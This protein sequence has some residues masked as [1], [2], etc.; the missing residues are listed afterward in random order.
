MKALPIPLPKKRWL[1]SSAWELLIREPAARPPIFFRAPAIDEGLRVN[2]T[3]EAS[4]RNSRCRDTALLMSRPKKTPMPP[5]AMKARP[6]MAIWPPPPF[7][8]LPLLLLPPD[9]PRSIQ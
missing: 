6:S 7:L 9:V 1:A 4:P 8:L 3:A 5:M 2:C